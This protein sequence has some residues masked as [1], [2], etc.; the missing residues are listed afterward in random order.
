MTLISSSCP[1][2]NQPVGEF[3]PCRHPSLGLPTSYVKCASFLHRSHFNVTVFVTA[4]INSTSLFNVRWFYQFTPVH[5]P[6]EALV[7]VKR[8]AKRR[9]PA[10]VKPPVESSLFYVIPDLIQAKNPCHLLRFILDIPSIIFARIV[11]TILTVNIN[12]FAHSICHLLPLK[13][14]CD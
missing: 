7:I 9:F 11:W 8:G 12:Y 14:A 6:P 3:F 10:G 5:R 13:I 1:N 4:I 2:L